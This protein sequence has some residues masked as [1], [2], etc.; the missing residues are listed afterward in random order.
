MTE[1]NPLA[2]RDFLLELWSD[3]P[4]DNFF[5]I[6]TMPDKRSR[7]FNCTEEGINEAANTIAGLDR[8]DVYMGVGLS[9]KSYGSRQRVSAKD[10]VG[11]S[12]LWAD[13]DVAGPNHKKPNLPPT[14]EDAIE[15]LNSAGPP[16]SI[17]VHSGNGLQAWWL[18][19][20]FNATT[21]EEDRK[22]AARLASAWNGNL[23]KQASKRGWTV[24]S[25]HDLARVMRV[26]GTTNQKG[27]EQKPVS[28]IQWNDHVYPQEDLW[29]HVSPTKP[30]ESGPVTSSTKRTAQFELRPDATPPVRKWDALKKADRNV[31][32]TF[33]HRRRDLT[34]QSPSGYDMALANFAAL[35]GWDDQEIV[36]LLI[37]HRSVHRHDLKL[38]RPDYYKR[39]VLK[40]RDTSA[41]AN[42]ADS[43]EIALAELDATTDE[44]S[45]DEQR[46][47]LLD[48][49]SPM[50]RTGV[51]RVERYGTEPSHFRMLTESGWVNLGT[52]D[53]LLNQ[54]IVRA[55]LVEVTRSVFPRTK[56]GE[57]DKI[58]EGIVRAAI[59]VDMGPEPTLIG[60]MKGWLEDYLEQHIPAEELDETVAMSRTPFVQN[61]GDDERILLFP[62]HFRTWLERSDNEK[63]SLRDLTMRLRMVGCDPRKVNIMVNGRPT[64][65]SVWRLPKGVNAS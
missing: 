35:A 42:A 7:W 50:L 63:L 26:P 3:A 6:W 24:D 36:D 4:D 37:Y 12:A 5:L 25:T 39:T 32:A 44:A 1:M 31:E 48:D 22:K 16:P 21:S 53:Q 13:I 40:A 59:D 61:F 14:Q 2:A 33:E 38:N 49:L 60:S 47:K 51:L 29:R 43:I 9:G 30:N 54:N 65:R 10:V 19:Y 55:R 20:E 23:Q 11:I 18:F 64:S 27:G 62:S 58:A 41:R 15:L 8:N 46:L 34:D 52:S 56:G 45:R 17:I 28:V 57:W